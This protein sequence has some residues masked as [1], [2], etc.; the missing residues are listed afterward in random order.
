MIK[1]LFFAFL[2]AGYFFFS[3]SGSVF[4]A[5]ITV[6][7]SG[8]D[9][10]DINEAFTHLTNGGTIF[11]NTTSY[12]NNGVLSQA[13]G[14]SLKLPAAVK[15]LTIKGQG[16]DK[17]V[18]KLSTNNANGHQ[19]H[20]AGLSGVK[21]NL[22]D[23]AFKNNQFKNSSVHLYDTNSNCELN[24]ERVTLEGSQAAG[25]F[26]EG[27]N[28]GT[29][30]NSNFINNYYP[31]IGVNDTSQV[32]VEGSFFKNH[33]HQAITAVDQS[34]LEIYGCRFTGNNVLKQDGANVAVSASGESDLIAKNNL[35]YSN[36]YSG[37]GFE[38][39]GSVEVANNTSFADAPNSFCA[40]WVDSPASSI[41]I[42]NNIAFGQSKDK[43][44]GFA[45]FSGEDDETLPDGA[46]INGA[47]NHNLAW[48]NLWNFYQFDDFQVSGLVANPL[49]V[50]TS[51]FHLQAGSPAI[52]TGDPTLKDPDGTRSDIGAYGGPNACLLDSTLAGC[53]GEV[54][55]RA[56][57]TVKPQGIYEQRLPRQARIVLKKADG[58]VQDLSWQAIS[59][60]S[61]GVYSGEFSGFAAGVYDLYLTGWSHLTKKIAGVSL[62]AGETVLNFQAVDFLGG[63]VNLDG[64]ISTLDSG[65]L[66]GDYLPSYH[67]RSD[68]NADGKVNTLDFG[69]L[70]KNYYLQGDSWQ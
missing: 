2:F 9:Y 70:V 16:Q 19:L 45:L 47:I 26:Y 60:N 6:C 23:L 15:E 36:H 28:R 48:N 30:K 56:I 27:T 5:Q 66:I 32:R 34:K 58:T 3:A 41:A 42:R 68:F 20:I 18:W 43:N 10:D 61:G 57:F 25:V 52:N 33:Q 29:I 53:Q 17:T 1:K 55:N 22:Q 59:S 50:S 40:F 46:T 44:C 35:F 62:L 69:Y 11:L 4:A 64:K 39:E 65:F 21:I 31:G 54:V 13:S 49:F 51:N 8:C 12:D 14:W 38:S 37:L 24:L 67:P 7:A 63:D